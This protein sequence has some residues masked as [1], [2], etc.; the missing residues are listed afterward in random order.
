MRLKDLKFPDLYITPEG[1]A[2][3][4]DGKTQ[5][6]LRQVTEVEDLGEIKAVLERTYQALPERKSSYAIMHDGI[7]FRVERIKTLTGIHYTARRFPTSVP[8]IMELNYHKGLLNYFGSLAKSYGI[9][10]VSGGTGSGKTTLLSCILKHFLETEGGFAYTIED[11][12]E[13]PLDGYYKASNGSIG[14]CK[15]TE[16]PEGAWEKGIMSALRSHPR[17]ILVGE[18]RSA[19]SAS[20]ALRAAT[21]GHLV[22][23]T[24][25]ANSIEDTITAFI[26]YA[27][28]SMDQDLATDLLARSA[29]AVINQRL[30]IGPDG[31]KS[32]DV[33]FLFLNPD[34]EAA[35]QARMLIR[36]RS[37]QFQTL[38]EQ[39]VNKLNRG[40]PFFERK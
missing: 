5:S 21:S 4:E 10:V 32:P 30:L 38:M 8:N 7:K 16:P 37:M 34:L 27:Q 39:Q 22:I 26:K 23:T 29:L 25:H 33:K 18:I 28:G 35:D 19:Q 3:I 11:P 24:I 9:I 17:Y 6:G 31:K 1:Y 12:P 36:S 40:A 13:F 20:E 15:Q 2:F 14:I